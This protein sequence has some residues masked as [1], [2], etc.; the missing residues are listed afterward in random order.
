MKRTTGIALALALLTVLAVGTIDT[1]PAEAARNYAPKCG[2]GKIQLTADEKRT[3]DLHNKYRRNNGVRQL[4]V[5]PR[6]QRAA[7]AHSADMLRRDYFSH[8]TKGRNESSCERM[9][10]Y[11][12][13]WR[14]CAEN[15]SYGS[16][17]KGAP[18]NTMKRWKDSL[19]HRRNILNNRYREVGVGVRKGTYERS[20]NVKMYTV[21]FGSR[22]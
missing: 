21:D 7:R 4:C 15:I 19:G 17:K 5:H 13:R 11:G 12:Y 22:R 8:D 10:R 6:L 20:R 1:A 3:F 2:G 9:R 18:A 16:G 14:A